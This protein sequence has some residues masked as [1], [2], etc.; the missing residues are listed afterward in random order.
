MEDLEEKVQM[1]KTT[2]EVEYSYCINN[3]LQTEAETLEHIIFEWN[4]I[5][6]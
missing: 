5:F 4:E 2:L 3:N 6:S 1:F